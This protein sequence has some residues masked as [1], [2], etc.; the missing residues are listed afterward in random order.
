MACIVVV[1]DNRSS[2]DLLGRL[3]RSV[4]HV[5][6]CIYE[7][8]AAVQAIRR[9]EPDILILDVNL[10]DMSGLEVLTQLRAEPDWHAL[11]VVMLSGVMDVSVQA[12]ALARGASDYIVKGWDWQ[13]LLDRIE[14]HLPGSMP[15]E[16]VPKG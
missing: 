7:G 9:F 5:V 4:G 6:V 10:P 1:D 8:Q 15:A 3:L 16:D 14:R 13:T 11:P 2:C 12:M